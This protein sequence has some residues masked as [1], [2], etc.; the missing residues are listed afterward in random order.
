MAL[1]VKGYLSRSPFEILW[2]SLAER[3][4][5]ETLEAVHSELA[6]RMYG[7]MS[8]QDKQVASAGIRELDGVLVARYAKRMDSGAR[9]KADGATKAD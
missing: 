6:N 2:T 1:V 9:L 4:S 8:A 3:V 5:P 7:P